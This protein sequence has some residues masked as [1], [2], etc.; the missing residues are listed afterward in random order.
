M[1]G[2]GREARAVAEDEVLALAGRQHVAADAADDD[3]VAAA[4]GDGVAAAEARRRR[5]RRDDLDVVGVIGDLPSSRS[6]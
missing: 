5:E 4:R 1:I 3:V 2:V 6:R